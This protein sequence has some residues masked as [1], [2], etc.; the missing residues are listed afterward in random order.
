MLDDTRDVILFQ[1]VI[2][3]D[4]G[5]HLRQATETFVHHCYWNCAEL[6][7][8]ARSSLELRAAREG[9]ERAALAFREAVNADSDFVIYKVLVGYDSIFPPAWNERDFPYEKVEA[10]RGKEISTLLSTVSDTSADLWFDR[11]C[12]Y[13][14]TE[15]DDLAT[16]PNFMAFLQGM[17]EQYPAIALRYLDELDNAIANFLPSILA[18]LMSGSAE[19]QAREW[20]DRSLSVGKFVG[21]IAWYLR[22]AEPLDESI[23]V[24]VLQSAVRHNDRR[25]V[26]NCLIASVLQFKKGPGT[27]I[28]GVFLPAL[29]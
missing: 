13:A 4:L 11:I 12:R 28:G 22:I 3:S 6:P 8:P 24:R 9:V 10:Y 15:S 14:K 1:T 20:I 16:F 27:L 29:T 19:P 5:L 2:L 17:A 18:G 25:A 26:R 21:Q 7:E 23:L